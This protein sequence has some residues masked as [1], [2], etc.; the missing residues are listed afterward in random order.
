TNVTLTGTLYPQ[1]IT[2]NAATNYYFL[3]AGKLSG[4]ASL[5]KSGSGQLYVTN[6]GGNDF[7]GPIT[8]SAGILKIGRAD[9]F[10]ATNGSTTISSGAML[11]L[12]GIGA[13]S[14]GELV[15]ISGTGLT[16]AGAI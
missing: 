15:T 8:V 12:G 11:D 5:T 16:K 1:S 13:N 6:T 9:A 2:V 3:G 14:P 7:T 4:N 10:G